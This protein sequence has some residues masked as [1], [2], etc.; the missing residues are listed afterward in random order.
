MADRDKNAVAGAFGNGA[1][2][3][4]AQPHAGD[5]R[6]LGDAEDLVD[7]A[8]PDDVDLRVAEQPV[9]QDLFGAQRV[10]AMDEGDPARVVGQI[11]RFLDRGVAAADDD[12][13]LVAEEE[14]V[15]GR[16]GRDAEAAKCRPRS[17]RRASA[18]ARRSR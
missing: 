3:Q 6:R 11:E 5:L 12:D 2:A 15:A 18:P 8:V 1:G 16:A 17:A 13:L 7:D 9:L 14:P 10:A 4:V